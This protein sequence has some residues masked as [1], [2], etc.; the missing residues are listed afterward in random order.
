MWLSKWRLSSPFDL[1]LNSQNE[2]AYDLAAWWR[3]ICSQHITLLVNLLSHTSHSIQT[4][5]RERE[6]IFQTERFTV[7]FLTKQTLVSFYWN[8]HCESLVLLCILQSVVGYKREFSLTF[9]TIRFNR[10]ILHNLFLHLY[11][12]WHKFITLVAFALLILTK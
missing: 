12:H 5:F 6:V 1:N 3:L 9:V 2:Q 11:V 7:M 8:L 4:V 10:T